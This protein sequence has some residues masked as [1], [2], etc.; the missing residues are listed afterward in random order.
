MAALSVCQP[1]TP[2]RVFSWNLLASVHTHWNFDAH[3]GDMKTVE[4][5]EQR[6]MRQR[7]IVHRIMREMPDVMLLQEVDESFLPLGWD[8]GFLPCGLPLAGYTAHRSYT[9]TSGVEEGV[10]ILLRDDVFELVKD[11]PKVRVGKSRDTG[12]KNGII[13]HARRC[14]DHSQV[15]CFASVHLRYGDPGPKVSL[16]ESL[17]RH[18]DSRY[19]ILLGGDFNTGVS[20][21]STLDA[22]MVSRG[23]KRLPS[24]PDTPTSLGSFPWTKTPTKSA[25]DMTIDHLYASSELSIVGGEL[26]EGVLHCA[27]GQLP[28]RPRGPFGDGPSDGSDHAWLLATLGATPPLEK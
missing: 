28:L 25:N 5:R 6:D 11:L 4:N 16:L 18:S 9:T 14:N 13:L 26:H 20:G 7:A 1:M 21:L 27:V 15:V 19:P 24:T 22:P 8:G 23:M 2:F 17:L 10:A 12:F 3:G